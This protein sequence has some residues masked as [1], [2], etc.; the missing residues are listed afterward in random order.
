MAASAAAHRKWVVVVREASDVAEAAD[1]VGDGDA[2]GVGIAD[3]VVDGVVGAA[4]SD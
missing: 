2:V 3:V 4:D 1:N